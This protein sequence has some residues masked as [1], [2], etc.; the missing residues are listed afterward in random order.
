MNTAPFSPAVREILA[1]ERLPALGPGQPNEPMRARL[2]RL[3]PEQLLAP[4]PV[5]QPEFAQACL[6]AVWLYHDFLDE[7]HRLSQEIHTPTGS[8]WHGILHRREPD[9]ANAKYWFRRIGEHPVF[10]PLGLAASELAAEESHA[11]A[12]FLGRQSAWD[13]FAFL[14]LCEASLSGRVP[15]EMLCRRVQRREWELLFDWCV[16]QAV[17]SSRG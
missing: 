13:P 5:R 2:A 12:A 6:A 1:E 7:S 17:E 14:D 10:E 3:T 11:G 8:Y 16:Q 15:C 4:E 9:F